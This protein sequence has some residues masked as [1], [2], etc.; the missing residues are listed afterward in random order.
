[1]RIAKGKS[2]AHEKKTAANQAEHQKNQKKAAWSS[3]RERRIIRGDGAKVIELTPG[4]DWADARRKGRTKKKRS[5][6]EWGEGTKH[7]DSF[8]F[9]EKKGPGKAERRR[10]IQKKGKK[11][12]KKIVL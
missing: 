4:G 12:G 1:M 5:G 11:R 7:P 10:S 3:V 6:R 2:V 9:L 8:Q